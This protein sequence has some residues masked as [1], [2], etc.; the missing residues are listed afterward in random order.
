MLT[1]FELCELLLVGGT[2][3][4]SSNDRAK[5]RVATRPKWWLGRLV[6]RRVL[7]LVVLYLFEVIDFVHWSWLPNW[8]GQ[9]LR[10][11]EA[12]VSKLPHLL[13]SLSLTLSLQLP[14]RHAP[15]VC[16]GIA[17]TAPTADARLVIPLQCFPTLYRWVACPAPAANRRCALHGPCMLRRDF[18]V[19]RRRRLLLSAALRSIKATAAAGM[20]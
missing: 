18:R 14:L 15:L 13:L 7:L 10:E 16:S 11:L 5:R 3:V 8:L 9:L 6:L 1:S 2:V 20:R 12:K 19:A 4:R 17:R